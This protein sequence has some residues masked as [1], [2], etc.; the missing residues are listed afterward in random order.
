MTALRIVIPMSPG[1]L[2]VNRKNAIHHIGGHAR[3]GTASAYQAA[4]DE[5]ELHIRSAVNRARW[6]TRSTE[7]VV[8]IESHWPTRRGDWDANS[9]TV[10]DLLAK[11]GVYTDDKKVREGSLRRFWR[12]DNPRIEITVTD[13]EETP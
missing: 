10:S 1:L 2:A 4:C 12:S 7:V 11:G 3:I 13:A 6:K 9:K 5:A 8:R